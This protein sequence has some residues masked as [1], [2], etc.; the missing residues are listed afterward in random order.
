MRK[1]PNN[2]QYVIYVILLL[3][4]CLHI[5]AAYTAF[6]N[7]DEGITSFSL[8]IMA[9]S[10]VPYIICLIILLAFGTP[11]KALGASLLI[12]IMDAWIYKD[13]FISPSGDLNNDGR[14]DLAVADNDGISAL[15][16]NPAAPGTFF[17]RTP[18]NVSGAASSVAI[19]DLNT[20]GKPDLVVANLA[21]VLVL[22]QDPTKAGSFSAPKNYGAGLQPVY[23]TVGDLDRGG[24]PDIAVE[25]LGSQSDASFASVFV[26]LQ[27]PAGPGSFLT[28]VNYKMDILAQ[29]F[30]RA[31][32]NGDGKADLAVGNSG[33]LGDLC[34]PN[35]GTAGTSVSVLLQNLAV[36]GQ[37]QTATDYPAN[38]GDFVMWVATGDMNGDGRMNFDEYISFRNLT[39]IS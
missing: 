8:D 2:L 19:A 22:L 33:S 34:P 36:P 26:L 29:A 17:P 15:F 1:S 24:K 10:I 28:V 7:S 32:L 39:S 30:A 12:L 13:V 5:Y 25:N 14:P 6:I 3:G 23:A 18:V 20:D 37:F 31:D 38:G 35:C 27:N 9:W 11:I 4:V 21:S 16:Q